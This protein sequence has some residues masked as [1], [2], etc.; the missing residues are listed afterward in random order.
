MPIGSVPER[1][2]KKNPGALMR[3]VFSC[4]EACLRYLTQQR[5]P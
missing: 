4:M 3:R 1:V 2:S 5:N